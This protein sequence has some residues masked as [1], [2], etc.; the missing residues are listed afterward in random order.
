MTAAGVWIPRLL[1]GAP[2]PAFTDDG[3]FC[4]GVYDGMPEDAYHADPVPGGS[5]SASGA[6]L[7][8]PPSCPALYRY[9]RDHPK[10]SAAF[11]YGTA[12]HKY[13]LG[14][15]PEIRHRRRPRLAHQGRAGGPQGARA[16]GHVP[17]L[18]ADLDEDR[19]M[20]RAIEQHPSPPPC[21]TRARPARAVPV[22]AGRGHR[23][24]AAGTA[25]LPARPRPAPGG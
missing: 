16:G 5:L 11:D 7:L 14:S 3:A 6:K 15:G 4:A 18:V 19:S 17:L 13:I 1:P 24:L 2:D 9:R 12:A 23:D 25:G 20:A 8:L 10:T 21:S 22:L